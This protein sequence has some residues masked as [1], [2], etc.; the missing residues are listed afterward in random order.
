MT[1]YIYF[2]VFAILIN[3]VI[4]VCDALSQCLRSIKKHTIFDSSLMIPLIFTDSVRD[5]TYTCRNIIFSLVNYTQNNIEI[6]KVKN[7]FTIGML[8]PLYAI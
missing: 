4:K 6:P 1:P 8:Y 2:H 3:G 5:E 7:I